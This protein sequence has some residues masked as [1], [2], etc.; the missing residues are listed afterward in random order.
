MKGKKRDA[1][2]IAIMQTF[3]QRWRLINSSHASQDVGCKCYLLMIVGYLYFFTN[4]KQQTTNNQNTQK[5]RTRSDAAGNAIA[6]TM[7][8]KAVPLDLRVVLVANQ[9]LDSASTSVT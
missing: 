2:L 6:D 7:M 8:L 3:S 9:I 4:N 1:S 5:I